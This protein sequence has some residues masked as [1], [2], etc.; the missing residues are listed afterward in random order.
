MVFF[1]KW[2]ELHPKA[3]GALRES[4][5]TV[6]EETERERERGRESE[7]ERGSESW[8]ESSGRGEASES[9]SSESF[10][11]E[12]KVVGETLKRLHASHPTDVDVLT[13]RATFL[14]LLEDFSGAQNLFQVNAAF[15]LLSLFCPFFFS[16]FYICRLTNCE[17]TCFFIYLFI[18]YLFYFVFFVDLYIFLFMFS[19]TDNEYN[20]IPKGG[21]GSGREELQPLEQTRRD[22]GQR[23]GVG[24]GGF[25]VYQRSR[26][27]PE[28]R[29]R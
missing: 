2:L 19:R 25:V 29:Q 10:L 24:E 7:R 4:A 17:T 13:A 5:A 20:T 6:A 1:R 23:S 12:Q 21:G 22:A 26:S 27:P 16:L 3:G 11:R 28:L 8:R 14:C 9:S 15:L 18:I